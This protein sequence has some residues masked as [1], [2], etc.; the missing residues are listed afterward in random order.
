MRTRKYWFLLI[1]TNHVLAEESEDSIFKIPQVKSVDT[2]E[3]TEDERMEMCEKAVEI[4]ALR[5]TKIKFLPKTETGSRTVYVIEVRGAGRRARAEV[6]EAFLCPTKPSVYLQVLEV[7]DKKQIVWVLFNEDEPEEVKF[8]G[9]DGNFDMHLF[10]QISVLVKYK[11]STS[12]AMWI[13]LM[14][15]VCSFFLSLCSGFLYLITA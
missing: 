6:V 5:K 12:L 13:S 7:E 15:F 10:F 2:D 3:L 9:E 8:A 1:F 4:D 11:T 14:F